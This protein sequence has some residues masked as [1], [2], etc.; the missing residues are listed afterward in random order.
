MLDP[1]PKQPELDDE[2]IDFSPNQD[3]IGRIERGSAWQRVIIVAAAAI[4]FFSALISAIGVIL[5]IDRLL[6][7]IEENKIEQEA[8]D[9]QH[10]RELSSL[11]DGLGEAQNQNSKLI[12]EIAALRGELE[13]AGITPT[14]PITPRGT[15]GGSGSSGGSSGGSNGGDG[16]SEPGPPGPTGPQGPPGEDAPPPEGEPPEEEPGLLDPLCQATG[17][18]LC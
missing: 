16:S 18:I 10:S 6:D 11:N 8:R 17:G 4:M 14:T 9:Q 12:E 1:P 13:S 15:N 2:D 5:V 3:L 7:Q